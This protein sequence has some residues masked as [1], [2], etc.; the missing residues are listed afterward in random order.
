[1]EYQYPT[2]MDWDKQEIIDVIGFYNCIELAYGKGIERDLL[3]ASYLRF[4]EIVPSKS[5]EK[6]LC[7]QFDKATGFSCYQ[8]VKKA[9]ETVENKIIK[10]NS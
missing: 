6:Q 9:R 7:G 1:M 2:S 3:V 4:K 5:E 8:T 10:M